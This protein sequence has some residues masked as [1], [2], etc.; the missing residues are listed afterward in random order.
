MNY[1]PILIMLIVILTFKSGFIEEF[2]NLISK[3]LYPITKPFKVQLVKPFN[4][5]FC[6]TFW[7]TIIY[8]IWGWNFNFE[9]LL[10]KILFSLVLAFMVNPISE[11]IDI[12]LDSISKLIVKIREFLHL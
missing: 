3:I 9:E 11:L 12:L 6:M 7:I 10:I 8:Q 1:L 2:E 4:C 5:D